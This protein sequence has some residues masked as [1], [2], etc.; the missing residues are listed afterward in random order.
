ML[1]AIHANP[2][3]SSAVADDAATGPGSRPGSPALSRFLP[4]SRRAYAPADPQQARLGL[5]HLMGDPLRDTQGVEDL[6]ARALS[7]DPAAENRLFAH[8]DAR[9]QA[10]AKRRIWDPE[11][12]RDLAQET[13]RTAA[14]KYREADLSRGFYPWLFAIFHN[15]VGNYL[16]RR[17]VEAERRVPEEPWLAAEGTA[18][19]DETAAIDL[20]RDLERGLEAASTECRRIFELLLGGAGRREIAAAF[21]G[22]PQGTIDS[23]ISRCRQRL[24]V[25]LESGARSRRSP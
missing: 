3:P 7:G 11:A 21:P 8:L 1:F 13:L 6:L 2:L 16:K 25:H 15:K 9:L 10:L 24:L 17:R 18:A 5:E 20:W 22:E 14:E 23:R 4:I 19:A 12:A